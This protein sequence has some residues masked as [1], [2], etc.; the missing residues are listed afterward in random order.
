MELLFWI[1]QG[2]GIAAIILLTMLK[3]N[4]LS[5]YLEE[6]GKNLAT[7]EDVAGITTIVEDIKQTYQKDF[8]LFKQKNDVF[9]DQI[10]KYN[11][12]FNSKQFELYNELW[13]SLIDLKISAD[14]LWESATTLKLK[15]FSQKVYNAKVSIAKSALLIED[16]HYKQLQKLIQ[17]FENFKFGK[18]QLLSMRNKS[19][20]DIENSI[21]DSSEIS[22]IIE[23]NRN[24]KNDY[25]NLISLLKVDFIRQIRGNNTNL[26]VNSEETNVNM[27]ENVMKATS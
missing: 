2:L 5:K 20:Q 7:K 22:E 26:T 24:F 15:D 13:S 1:L 23:H 11:E 21:Q 27:T 9:F 14:D 4:Y 8:E 6:K 3:T 19:R 17:Q 10:K 25:D 16:H 12:R 18:Q